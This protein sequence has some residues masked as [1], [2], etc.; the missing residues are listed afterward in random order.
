MVSLA[1]SVTISLLILCASGLW[2]MQENRYHIIDNECVELWVHAPSTVQAEKSF[3][4]H[5]QAWD[6]YERLSS[7]YNGEVSFELVSF[8]YQPSIYPI[9]SFAILPE[10]YTFSGDIIEQGL[11]PGHKVSSIDGKD[12]G[13]HTF[14]GKIMKAGIHYIRVKDNFGRIALSNPIQ[15]FDGEPSRYLY[16]GDIHGHS[17][18]CDGS[19]YLEDLYKFAKE[20]AYLDFASV[21][22]HD[23]WTDY[24][25]TA[26]NFGHLWEIS[27]AAAN[28]W[29][30]PEDFVTLVSY[31]WT[32]QL[33]SY[34]HMCVYYKGDDGPMISSSYPWYKSQDLL[35]NALRE[36]K[37]SSGSDVITIPHHTGHVS[38]GMY[39]DWSF[40][41][42]EFVTL[43]EICSAHGSSEKV[44]GLKTIKPGE[45]KIHGYHVQ[46]ALAM[47]YKVGF[48]ASSDQ[49][50]G[51][52]GHPILHTD[53]NTRF[54]YPYTS[55]GLIGGF[56]FGEEY[57]GTLTGLYCDNLTRNGVFDALK[58]RS[59][60][61]STHVKRP[62]IDFS[63][64]GV[65][66]G[67]DNSTVYIDSLD[68][69]PYI[70]VFI[71]IDAGQEDNL[72]K[73]ITLVKNN[74]DI[75]SIK[76]PDDP[77]V[78]RYIYNDV[79]KLTGM[80][81]TYGVEDEN[82]YKITPKAKIYL[83][84]YSTAKPPSTNWDGAGYSDITDVYYVRIVQEKGEMAWIGPIW[85][86]LK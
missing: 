5:V 29:N 47:G 86:K 52:L 35:W 74:V 17:A 48:M 85:V 82:G 33:L 19:G 54:Q 69:S 81:Y 49:H 18:L 21:T 50:D 12:R 65:S 24:Y 31:E 13:K 72:I 11:I 76:P 1:R 4:F 83:S 77:L 34:G 79:Q 7:I 36:W 39:F 55:M 26:P 41:D 20:V 28:R 80:N 66:V 67:R 56:R 61:A 43:V 23:D 9:Y 22:T 8:A 37:Q 44:N 42:P 62:I 84:N 38:S 75:H 14:T 2:M 64:N 27:K 16:W 51:R 45:S 63:I 70:E 6:N 30:S 3:E 15:V 57:E 60:Y 46:D 59:C 71:A 10:N 25:G 58:Q 40:Y 73:N 68:Y 53:A 78:Y 32:A